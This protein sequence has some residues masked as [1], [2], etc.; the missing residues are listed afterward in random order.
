[1]GYIV[2][3]DDFEGPLEVLLQL[4]SK[5][6]LSIEDVSLSE[7][8]AQYM[9]YIEHMQ[10]M[11]MEI[12]SEFISL[13]ATLLYIKSCKLLPE[14]KELRGE[15]DNISESDLKI[16]LIE[17]SKIKQAAS[18]L[19]DNASAN[20]SSYYRIR[21]ESQEIDLVPPKS[22]D[23]DSKKL[24][25]AM[26]RIANK[27][28]KAPKKPVIHTLNRDTKTFKTRINELKL[29]FEKCKQIVFFELF[30]KRC[31]RFEIVLT[32]MAVLKLASDGMLELL[33]TR[34]FEDVVIRRKESGWAK[35]K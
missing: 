29:F 3:L 22:H 11:D 2:K 30:S 14:N 28:K 5:A 4:I 31:K 23:Y 16:K 13:A 25:E 32:F 1:M 24:S 17:Y 15:T 27:I 19:E 9:N 12:A 7:I 8:T 21:M 10:E 26:A 6:R 35:L 33:Q 18:L 34:P 20:S